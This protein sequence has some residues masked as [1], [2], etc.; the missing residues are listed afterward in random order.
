[1][2]LVDAETL[3]IVDANPALLRTLG[4]T[5]EEILPL[6]LSRVFTDQSDNS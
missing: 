3:S 2:L 4:Y 1:M 5:L 6:D